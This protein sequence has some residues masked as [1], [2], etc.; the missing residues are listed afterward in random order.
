MFTNK[1][2]QKMFINELGAVVDELDSTRQQLKDYS[3]S[4]LSDVHIHRLQHILH[5]LKGG[6]KFVERMDI[7]EYLAE[8]ESRLSQARGTQPGT[9]NSNR[10]LNNDALQ[11][12][13]EFLTRVSDF[14]REKLNEVA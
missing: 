6:A 2:L 7:A 4:V 11:I 9:N 10:D 5:R 12:D 8:V 3:F 14:L 13:R 1:K